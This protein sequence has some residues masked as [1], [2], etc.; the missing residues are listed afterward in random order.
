VVL[1][2][3]PMTP[4][5]WRAGIVLPVGPDGRFEIRSGHSD[6]LAGATILVVVGLSGT[7]ETGR[8]YL[9]IGGFIAKSEIVKIPSSGG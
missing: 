8:D 9:R 1:S 7:I 6:P 4:T 5:T 2:A 3:Q